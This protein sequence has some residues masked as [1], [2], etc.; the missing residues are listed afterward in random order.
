MSGAIGPV[1]FQITLGDAVAASFSFAISALY[2]YILIFSGPAEHV[3]ALL[4][5]RRAELFFTF[6]LFCSSY[7][8]R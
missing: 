7:T 4:H 5:R 6:G 3:R 2:N 1:L 8:Q